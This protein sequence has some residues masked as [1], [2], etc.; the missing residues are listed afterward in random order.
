MGKNPS[1]QY[2]ERTFTHRENR[3][4]EVNPRAEETYEHDYYVDDCLVG[5]FLLGSLSEMF[6]RNREIFKKK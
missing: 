4:F 3:L 6:E 5:T 1:L 2:T